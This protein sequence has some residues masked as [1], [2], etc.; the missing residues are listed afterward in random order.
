MRSLQA[1]LFS[2]MLIPSAS[3]AKHIA[4]GELSYVYLGA[5]T[6]GAV[7]YAFTLRLYRDC[8]APPDAA[9][10]DAQAR[11]L[12]QQKG[13]G[14]PFANL[15]VP[16]LKVE[17]SELLKPDPCFFNRPSVCYD[18][19]IYTFTIELP[20]TAQGYDVSYQ[21][22]CRIN[23]IANVINSG[24]A[25]ANYVAAVPGQLDH[26]SGHSNNSPVFNGGDTVLICQNSPFT[27]DFSARD[28]DGDSLV[29]EFAEAYGNSAPGSPYISLDYAPAYTYDRPMGPGVAIDR[30][31]GIMSG[32]APTAGI[33]V[34]TVQVIE[35]RDGKR[36]N[37]HR[38]DLHIKV[39]DC[40]STAVNLEPQYLNCQGFTLTFQNNGGSPLIRT[41]SWDFGVPG[42]MNDTSAQERPTFT[43]P[44]SGV[45]RVRLIT[46]RNQLCS[47]TGYTYASVFPGFNAGFTVDDGCK[48]VPLLFTD[49][50]RAR[51]GKVVSW[52]WDF[53]HPI[54][55]PAT[56]TLQNPKYTYP[57][58]GIY[59]VR[60]I[61][62]SSMGCTDTVDKK[63]NILGRPRLTV[64]PD[65]TICL[66]DTVQLLATGAGSF[67]W[68]SS[69]SLSDTSIPDPRAFPRTRTRYHVTLT[70]GPGCS[71]RDSVEIDVKSNLSANAGRDTAVLQGQPLR[72][73]ASGGVR[74]LWSPATGLND[75]E[76][77]EPRV[78][79]DR[80][81]TYFLKAISIEG[82][83]GM[84]TVNIRVFRTDPDI[85]VPTAFTPNGDRLNDVLT[86]IPVGIVE[87]QFFRVYNRWG[88]LVYSTNETGK[89][90]DG[91]FKGVPQ[92]SGTFAWHVRG[93]A[94]D[95]RA[96]EKRG[97]ATIIR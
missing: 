7:R 82:C 62:S 70:S 54:P 38:K 17:R 50:T 92:R 10:L 79:T 34:V 58:N 13:S 88:Q 66:G 8:G 93:L 33:Y 61:V 11:I 41:Y 12:I 27:Y 84:D 95:G 40:S 53:G 25:G 86:P 65:R 83:V 20:L 14:L 37:R 60:L 31:T 90:W 2:L 16:L 15:S 75:P 3:E 96:V 76:A 9:P 85:F 68:S 67:T 81:R 59:D 49:T 71:N 89:G 73:K 21:Q 55:N 18:V 44:D 43:F 45:Y 32:R 26:P 19:G 39:A 46:N 28:S 4:G 5:G 87:F 52:N 78:D 64:T 56:S 29:Y 91:M 57:T 36:V 24:V 48:D 97:T 63:V 1:L 30:K 72:L 80:D 23:G 69:A 6:G 22:C 47:D 77:A 35:Y 74:Y 42:V 94:I 51:Y